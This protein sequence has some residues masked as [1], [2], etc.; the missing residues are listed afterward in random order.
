MLGKQLLVDLMYNHRTSLHNV[1]PTLNTL[2]PPYMLSRKN[3]Q[4]TPTLKKLEAFKEVYGKK[5]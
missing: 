5:L 3:R 1:K 2:D 4:S